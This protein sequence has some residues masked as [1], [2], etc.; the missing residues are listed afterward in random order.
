MAGIDPN[1]QVIC[2]PITPFTADDRVDVETL[3][4]HLVRMREAGCAIYLA[5]GGTGES[6]S[7]TLDELEVVYG[8]GVDVCGGKVPVYAMA[9][10]G[11]TGA[12]VLEVASI[13]HKAGVDLVQFYGVDMGHGLKPTLQEQE[14][15]YRDLLEHM[16]YPVALSIHPIGV[17]YVTPSSLI[18]A[19]IKEYPQ[20]TAL[21]IMAGQPMSTFVEFRD[22]A[23][24]IRPSIK[25]YT[26]MSM[27]MEGM[28]NGSSG[29]L[30]TE[31]NIVPKLSKS[32]ADRFAQKDFEGA[33]EGMSHLYRLN[34]ILSKWGPGPARSVKTALKVLGL[35]AGHLRLPNM[36][37]PEAEQQQV[38]T[39][40]EAMNI[41]ELEG[42]RSS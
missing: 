38:L 31:P 16:D 36:Y 7:L 18:G 29:T 1:P 22:V 19:L 40:L 3:R 5:G 17:G 28:L 21:N 39:E 4:A 25:L 12:Q 33:T 8:T 27:L 26:S 6:H 11:H 37:P 35:P 30:A 9:R 10:E 2:N 14:R 23:W 13:A 24:S 41:R 20:I 34:N 42:L 32:I 15:Y